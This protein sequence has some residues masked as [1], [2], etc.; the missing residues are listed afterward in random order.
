MSPGALPGGL[1]TGTGALTHTLN[2][3]IMGIVTR[4][5][6][7]L[8]ND[9]ITVKV[10]KDDY[11]PSF[12]KA[13]KEYS[14][15]ANIPG[16]RKGMVP[17][18]LIKKMYGNSVFADEVLRSVEKQLTDYMASEKLDIFAQPLPLPE[19]DARQIQM[20]QPQEYSFAF[21]V[22]LKPA[23]DLPD[24]A[25]MKPESLKVQVTDEMVNEEID[26]L[27]VRH[28]KMTEPESVTSDDHVLNVT[29]EES[30][31]EGN[32][33]E[34]GIRKDNSLLVKYF[35]PEFRKNLFGKKKEDSLV[36]QVSQAFDDKE[37]EWIVNDLGLAGQDPVALDKFFKMTITK[38]GLVEKAALDETFFN[39]V[40]PEKEIT[41]EEAFRSA[42]RD[43]IGQY[44]DKQASHQLQHTL[45]HELLGD[46]RIEFPESFLKRWLQTGGEK[47][48]TQEEVESEFPT[49]TNQ[50]K[51]TLILDKIARE[52]NLE[53]TAEDIKA[54]ARQ[55]LMGYMGNMGANLD[56]QPWMTDYVNR[57]MQDRRFIEDAVHRIRTDKVL[58]W[59]ETQ[60]K[61]TEK[62]ITREDFLKMQE[63]HHHHHH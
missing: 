61:P 60:V 25:N 54:F 23:F 59:A 10:A 20:N 12:E 57:M 7:G 42:L 46:T 35:N 48:K 28:G 32:F 26:R 39:T 56:E 52:N 44:W 40:F 41:T 47:P 53:A 37:R 5:N 13:L 55:Q 4:E 50:L 63:E 38:V 16:F 34:G 49:F 43:E 15:K 36:L 8:L 29:F 24:F 22:G 27:Q 51:W 2:I 17:A 18:G 31:A 45:Y 9:K 1:C 11:L 6:I 30:D 62:P 33:V 19:N 21:E 3:T 58:G 14:K